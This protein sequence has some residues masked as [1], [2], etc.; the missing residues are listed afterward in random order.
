M[1]ATRVRAAWWL[2]LAVLTGLAH[3]LAATEGWK[4]KLEVVS[5]SYGLA[6]KGKPAP[7][8]L[9]GIPVG[10]PFFQSTR[11]EY[12]YD[13]YQDPQNIVRRDLTY[14]NPNR[15]IGG[16]T[17]VSL[18]D[19]NTGHVLAWNKGQHEAERS[20]FVP[21]V[22]PSRIGARKILGHTC[23]GLRH[24]WAEENGFQHTREVWYAADAD[25]KDPLLE[26][27]CVLDRDGTLEYLEIRVMT[28]LQRASNIPATLFEEP[29]NLRVKN[30]P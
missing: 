21:A 16:P 18:F 19:Y 9:A 29:P 20:A 12:R 30:I 7:P 4:G 15:S 5:F 6:Q 25:F 22:T 11:W 3:P 10:P 28:V 26:M 23:E 24:K 1:I 13:V 8:N 2:I 14:T 27:R 17:D